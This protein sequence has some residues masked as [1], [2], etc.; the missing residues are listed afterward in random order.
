MSR[1]FG[2][3]GCFPRGISRS[4]CDSHGDGGVE[5]GDRPLEARAC[6]RVVSGSVRES[7]VAGFYCAGSFGLKGQSG[8]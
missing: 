4:R 3:Q 8:T 1:Y 7:S 5:S 2:S 6:R